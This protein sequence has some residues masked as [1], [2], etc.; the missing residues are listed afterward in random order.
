MTDVHFF[1]Y[2]YLKHVVKNDEKQSIE[3]QKDDGS[4]S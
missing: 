3:N 4:K 2:K 1:L